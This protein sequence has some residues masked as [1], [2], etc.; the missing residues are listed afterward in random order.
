MPKISQKNKKNRPKAYNEDTIQR[1]L[2][3]I[4]NGAAKKSVARKYGIPRATLQFRLSSKFSKIR[5]GPK[6][7]LT[8]EEE[9]QLVEW[10]LENQRKGFPKRKIDLQLSVKE[11]LDASERPNP[12]KDNL[13]GK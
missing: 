1:A 13:P 10:I 2:T 12:F 9:H 5:H 6:T 7:Y 4:K 3:E 8:D 11:F